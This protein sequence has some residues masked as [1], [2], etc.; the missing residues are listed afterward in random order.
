MKPRSAAKALRGKVTV[1]EPLMW[2]TRGFAPRSGSRCQGLSGPMQMPGQGV[3]HEGEAEEVHELPGVTHRVGPA[4]VQRVLHSSLD[5]LGVVA[6]PVQTGEVRIGWTD[7]PNV[8][9]PVEPPGGVLI[10]PVQADRDLPTTRG[11]WLGKAGGPEAF[12]CSGQ[13]RAASLR[14]CVRRTT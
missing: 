2:D 3:H 12:R 7:D 13:P 4:Q 11:G 10:R 1:S 9:R 5:G 14:T 8:L 6:P